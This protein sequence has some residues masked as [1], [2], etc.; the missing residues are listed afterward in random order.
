MLPW[1]LTGLVLFLEAAQKGIATALVIA[2]L[3]I[4]LFCL[5]LAGLHF[6]SREGADY[7]SRPSRT[8][9]ASGSPMRHV[10]TRSLGRRRALPESRYGFLPERT[11]GNWNLENEPTFEP[12]AISTRD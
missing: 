1:S 10:E 2:A 7:E 3:S 8:P 12:N 4:T 9:V 6:C 11:P 5:L